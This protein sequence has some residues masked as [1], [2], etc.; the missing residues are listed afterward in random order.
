MG[1]WQPPVEL[2][3]WITH[4]SHVLHGRLAGRLL[5]LLRGMLFA[6]GRRTVARWLRAAGLGTAYRSS[7]YF[8]GSLGRKV[9][10]VAAHLLRLAVSVIVPGERLLFGLDDTPTKRYGPKVQGAGIHHNPSPGPADQ[11]FLYG[12]LGVTIAWIVRHPLGGA[13]GLPLRAL[14]YVRCQ[15]VAKLPRPAKV[16]FRTKLEMAASLVA[17]VA[18]GLHYLGKTLW[19]AA[20]GAYAQRPFLQAARAAHVVVVS[21]LR[22][23]AALGSVPQ[24]PRPGGAQEAWP[25]SHLGQAGHQSGQAGGTPPRLADRGV[26]AVPQEGDQDVQDVPGH[27]QAGGRADSGGAGPRGRRLGGVL[28]HRSASDGGADPGSG[29]GPG[30]DRAGLPR[31]EGSAWGRSAAGAVLLGQRGGVSPE[32]L[33]AH[34][35][36]AVGLDAIAGAV[37]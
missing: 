19:V 20:D 32:P 3:A 31:G 34:L 24:L 23:D 17:W 16:A 33:A 14:L 7:Y 10:Y 22:K 12:H 18:D 5:P 13:I 29:R 25:A 4:L 9:E 15:D 1:E 27:L 2:L 26:G 11:K 21:R 37:V 28:L 6:Q 8:L 30:G 36:R 35:S